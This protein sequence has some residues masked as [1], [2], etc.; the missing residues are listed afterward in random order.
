VNAK[1][2]SC[3]DFNV[4]RIVKGVVDCMPDGDRFCPV[5]SL[6]IIQE[7]VRSRCQLLRTRILWQELVTI[8]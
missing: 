5:E 6:L 7:S 4:K 1:S 3:N 8:G 2:R